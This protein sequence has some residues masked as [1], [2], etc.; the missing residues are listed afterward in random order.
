MSECLPSVTL[1][2]L[3]PAASVALISVAAAVLLCADVL[4]PLLRRC[5]FVEMIPFI[6]RCRVLA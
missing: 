6:W 5:E 1:N 2:R 4:I 3:H